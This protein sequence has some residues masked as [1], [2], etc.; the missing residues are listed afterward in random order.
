MSSAELNALATDVCAKLGADWRVTELAVGR[1]SQ[2]RASGPDDTNLMFR[3][4]GGGRVSI[5][6]VYPRHDV[7]RLGTP[8]ITVAST[9]TSGAIARD[10]TRRLLP[11]YRD[12]LLV[13]RAD[14]RQRA[15]YHTA[16]VALAESLAAGLA[17]ARVT[18]DGPSESTQVFT[19]RCGN[20]PG[21]TL[22]IG[23]SGTSGDVEITGATADQLHRILAQL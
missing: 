9:R 19:Y 2:V 17:D 15:D 6:G 23:R 7:Y 20:S 18:D 13:V 3:W 22:R 8:R 4:V 14:N 10:V 5:V 12:G 21:V 11:M 16:R 1:Y